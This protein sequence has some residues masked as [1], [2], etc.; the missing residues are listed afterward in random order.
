MSHLPQGGVARGLS[1]GARETLLADRQVKSRWSQ[2]SNMV[3]LVGLASWLSFFRTPHESLPLQEGAHRQFFRIV[4]SQV[5]VFDNPYH[6]FVELSGFSLVL[7]PLN[8]QPPGCATR[9]CSHAG[10]QKPGGTFV[11]TGKHLFLCFL[12]IRWWKG[13]SSARRGLRLWRRDIWNDGRISW[14]KGFCNE[15]MARIWAHSFK[16]ISLC[17]ISTWQPIFLPY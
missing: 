12:Y 3:F 6:S 10:G 2:R 7:W 5:F 9:P 13:T 1:T 8:S 16:Y 4:T 15:S 14:E 17:I 11:V